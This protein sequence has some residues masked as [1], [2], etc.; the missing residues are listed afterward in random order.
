MAGRV[1]TAAVP[2]GDARPAGVIG[3]PGRLAQGRQPPRRSHGPPHWRE[4]LM[5]PR[6]ATSL[7]GPATLLSS[8]RR[9]RGTGTMADSPRPGDLRPWLVAMAGTRVGV[10][11]LRSEERR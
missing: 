10:V 1:G 4:L 9:L 11:H 3:R 6:T 2:R 7:P 8:L 5:H